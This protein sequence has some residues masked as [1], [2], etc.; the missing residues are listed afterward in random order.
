MTVK[1]DF[2]PRGEALAVSRACVKESFVVQFRGVTTSNGSEVELWESLNGGAF[3]KV[4]KASFIGSDISFPKIGNT[5][6]LNRYFFKIIPPAAKLCERANN[7]DTVA[8]NIEQVPLPL[9]SVNDKTLL[10]TNPDV[11]AVYRWQVKESTASWKDI[12]PLITTT[13]FA[14]DTSG[15]YR[16]RAEKG[17]CVV[18]SQEKSVQ[19]NHAVS[20]PEVY[21]GPNPTT[22]ILRIDSL[23]LTDGWQT[24][25]ILSSDGSQGMGVYNIENQTSVTINVESLRPGFYYAVLR[26]NNG[27]P[28]TIKFIKI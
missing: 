22:G 14:P 18:F 2:S 6:G 27:A 9:L 25:E 8:I 5:L 23:K 20:A 24:L 11:N 10:V 28:V 1:S 17:A 19:I 15:I 7:S 16:V 21:Y 4:D 3:S 26:R 13:S 12:L